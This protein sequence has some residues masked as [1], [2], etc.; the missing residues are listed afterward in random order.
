MT[1]GGRNLSSFS[2]SFFHVMLHLL[3][4]FLYF[5][6]W[7]YPAGGVFLRF[8]SLPPA[9]GHTVCIYLRFITRGFISRKWLDLGIQN[10]IVDLL[11]CKTQLLS[12]LLA[13]LINSLHSI[14]LAFTSRRNLGRKTCSSRVPPFLFK[15][16]PQIQRSPGLPP[17]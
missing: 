13:I 14:W 3:G 12:F 7:G 6:I 10:L 4:A 1:A 5:Y 2:S 9:F 16:N 8:F 17:L 15:G 11:L